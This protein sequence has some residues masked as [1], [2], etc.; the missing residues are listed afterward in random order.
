MA[1]NQTLYL[2]E[3]Q[4]IGSTLLPNRPNLNEQ[5]H[6]NLRK[7]KPPQPFP[8]GTKVSQPSRSERGAALKV[9]SR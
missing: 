5:H 7:G 9:L 1:V 2:L 3:K 6:Q 4:R 8:Q